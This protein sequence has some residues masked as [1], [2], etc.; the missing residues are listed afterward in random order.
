MEEEGSIRIFLTLNLG[1]VVLM[2]VC[3]D[4]SGVCVRFALLNGRRYEN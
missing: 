3:L 2:E 1:L 4:M